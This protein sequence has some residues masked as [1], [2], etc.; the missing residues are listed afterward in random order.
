LLGNT[1]DAYNQVWH[2]PTSSE[3]LTGKEFV[4]LFA[5]NM[6]A[7]NKI[8]VVSKNLVRFLGIFNPLMRELV[9][10]M[11]QYEQDYFFDSAKFTSRFPEFKITSYEEGVKAVIAAGQ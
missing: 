2:L 9:E 11:Y 5:A 1:T 4:Q 7:K 3:K 6:N 10:M 8:S